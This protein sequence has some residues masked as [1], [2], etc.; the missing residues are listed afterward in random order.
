VTA[1]PDRPR[2]RVLA[3]PWYDHAPDARPEH[4]DGAGHDRDCA[5]GHELLIY[6]V[7][8]HAPTPDEVLGVTQTPDRDA[9]RFSAAGAR[10]AVCDYVRL[11]SEPMSSRITPA[12]VELYLLMPEP[13]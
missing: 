2:Y 13:S 10:D 12:D 11:R 9:G 3:R 5:A 4:P 8:R 7:D 6:R 1:D